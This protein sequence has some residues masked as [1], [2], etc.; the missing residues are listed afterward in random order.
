[1]QDHVLEGIGCKQGLP[2]EDGGRKEKTVQLDGMEI[3][4]AIKLQG[5]RKRCGKCRR[6]A[7]GFVGENTNEGVKPI[8]YGTPLK[9]PNSSGL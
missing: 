5:G 3:D 1:M 4:H 2:F 8:I 6:G 9:V 7:C